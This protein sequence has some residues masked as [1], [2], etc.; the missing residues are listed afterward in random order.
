MPPGP[1]TVG[2]G[3]CAS[4]GAKLSV[5]RSASETCCWQCQ[6]ASRQV[7]TLPYQVMHDLT[8]R[9]KPVPGG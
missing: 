6:A 4:C 1:K 3:V 2:A 7:E 9:W 8:G 5:Y